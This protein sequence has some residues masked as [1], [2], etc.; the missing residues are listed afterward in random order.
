M[1]LYYARMDGVEKDYLIRET[2]LAAIVKNCLAQ[3]RTAWIRA[4]I[5][6][7]VDISDQTVYTDEKMGWVYPESDSVELLSVL[8]SRAPAG[9]NIHGKRSGWQ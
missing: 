8:Q 1:V 6:V 3:C 4:G 2:H 7:S 9:E 5:M